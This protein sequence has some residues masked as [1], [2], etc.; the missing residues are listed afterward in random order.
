MTLC[1][2][3]VGE[4]DD[5]A[6]ACCKVFTLELGA[7]EDAGGVVVVGVDGEVEEAPSEDEAVGPFVGPG[8][9]PVGVTSPLEVL[10]HA[11][12]EDNATATT[13]A[14]ARG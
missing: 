4:D 10:L 7:A 3:T 8:M 14:A 13:S 2:G 12:E 11:A 9:V 6:D 1:G 5:G